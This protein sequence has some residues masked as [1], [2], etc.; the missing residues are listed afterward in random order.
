M[1]ASYPAFSGRIADEPPL[2]MCYTKVSFARN[3]GFLA[4][5]KERL[6]VVMKLSFLQ[7]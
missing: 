4:E 6:K 1:K 5:G 2:G 3:P 7:P